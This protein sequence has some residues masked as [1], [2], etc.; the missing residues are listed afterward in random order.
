MSEGNSLQDILTGIFLNKNICLSVY[1][2]MIFCQNNREQHWLLVIACGTRAH[3]ITNLLH[4]NSSIEF[5][6]LSDV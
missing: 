5:N 2:V 4:G 3:A 1:N 6:T